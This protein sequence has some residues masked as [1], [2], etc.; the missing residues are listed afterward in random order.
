M[1]PPST[2]TSLPVVRVL[3]E[4]KRGLCLSVE[5]FFRRHEYLARVATCGVQAE[6]EWKW[7]KLQSKNLKGGL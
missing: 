2:P 1:Q 6:I 3:V 7:A 4:D 5:D